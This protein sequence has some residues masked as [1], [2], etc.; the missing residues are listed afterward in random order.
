MN[1]SVVVLTRTYHKDGD[2]LEKNLISTINIFLNRN[3]YKFGIILDDES[4]E[5]H[6]LGDYL[7]NRTDYIFYETLPNKYLELFQALAYPHMS[8]GY[9]RQQWSTFYFDTFVKEDIIGIVDSDSTFTSYLTN[10]NFIKDNKI[11][12]KGISPIAPYVNPYHKDNYIYMSGSHYENDNIA[13]GF[14]TKYNLM[15]T[16]LMPIFF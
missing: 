7:L 15:I 10:N 9:D 14:E 5:D 16:N 8:W 4:L 13:L 12:I 6:I 2:I 11:L 1:N 3:K